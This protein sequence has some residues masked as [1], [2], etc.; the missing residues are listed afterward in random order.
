[1]EQLLSSFTQVAAPGHALG[2]VFFLNVFKACGVIQGIAVEK[3]AALIFVSL[4]VE[5]IALF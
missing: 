2:A 3:R 1:M 4:F 5:S